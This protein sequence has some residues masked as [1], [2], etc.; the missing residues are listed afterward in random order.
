M[1]YSDGVSDILNSYQI[2]ILKC[3]PP[4]S[5]YNGGIRVFGLL[6]TMIA[7]QIISIIWLFQNTDAETFSLKKKIIFDTFFKFNEYGL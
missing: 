7:V 6:G 2:N 4:S 3:Y 1:I 5:Y